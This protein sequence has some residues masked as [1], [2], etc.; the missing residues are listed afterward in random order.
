LQ[1]A[2]QHLDRAIQI[3]EHTP[4][5]AY[6]HYL[7][8]KVYS[9]QNDAQKAVTQL[10]EAVSLQ[11]DFAEAW[12]DLGLARKTILDDQG[13][14]AA[15]K[16]AVELKPTDAVAQYRLGTEYLRAGETHAAIEPLEQAYRINP[17]D[18]STLNSL[19]SA[20]RQDG[21]PSEANS[22]RQKLAA[23][24]QKKDQERQNALAAVRVNNEGANLEK[25]G[26]LRGALQKYREALNLNPEHAGIRVNYA[27]ALLRLGQWTEG[28]TQLHEALRRDPGNTQI[29]AALKD[30]LAQAPPGS[31]PKWSQADRK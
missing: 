5:A 9:A 25:S 2:A 18:Q 13:A 31:V 8:A 6:P 29:Q 10:E 28:L 27:V 4:D 21:K 16:R 1:A 3:L 24:L 14:L 22:I 7:R 19:Q 12:S 11:P 15:Y 30:A 20:L 17:E 26:D 23:L